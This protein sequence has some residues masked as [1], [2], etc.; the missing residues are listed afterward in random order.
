M[1]AGDGS[2]TKMVVQLGLGSVDE[3]LPGLIIPISDHNQE[4]IIP[5]PNPQSY[6]IVALDADYI[7]RE[8]IPELVRR[9]FGDA[10]AGN[11]R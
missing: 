9:H 4:E 7:R 1:G 2:V 11:T 5:I 10:G 3:D 6:R 8:L